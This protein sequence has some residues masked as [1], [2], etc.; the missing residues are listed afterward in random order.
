MKHIMLSFMVQIN[1]QS[2]HFLDMNASELSGLTY[3]CIMYIT[4]RAVSTFL[5]LKVKH[6]SAGELQAGSSMLVQ[7]T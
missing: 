3:T 5:G 2:N 6:R 1:P 4:I 7:P